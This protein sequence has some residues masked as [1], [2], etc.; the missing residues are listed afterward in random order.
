[1]RRTTPG[2]SISAITRIGPLHFGRTSG[3]ASQVSQFMTLMS[4][5]IITTGTPPGVGMGMK[6]SP[7][8]LEP[9]DLMTLGIQG[10]GEQRQ[11]VVPWS[12]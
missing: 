6:P 11:K 4:G 10:L 7:V 3:S 8:F 9:G 5:D 12:G 2:S 1:M